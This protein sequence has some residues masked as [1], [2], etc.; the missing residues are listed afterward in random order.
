[1]GKWNYM[2]ES[3]GLKKKKTWPGIKSF[4]NGWLVLCLQR[5]YYDDQFVFVFILIKV[6]A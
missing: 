4:K 5:M 6:M 3:T 2:D 1:M